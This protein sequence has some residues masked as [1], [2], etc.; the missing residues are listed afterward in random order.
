M[1]GLTSLD[2]ERLKWFTSLTDHQLRRDTEREQGIFIAESEKVVRTALESGIEPLAF[3]L[4]DTRVA[5]LQR[6]LDEAEALWPG[7]P[8][9]VLPR[10][11][12]SQLVGYPHNRGVLCAMARPALKAPGDVLGGAR[13]VAVLEALTD[14]TNVGA[15]FRSAAALGCDGVLLTPTCADPLARRCVRVSMGSVFLVPWARLPEW[16]GAGLEL[17][18]EA[19]FTTC[20]CALREDAL[21]L[22][23]PRLAE[24][25]HLA[26][27]FG[28]EGDG[29][30]REAVDGA[31][32]VARIPMAHGVD[33][34]NVAAAS[35][36]FFWELCARGR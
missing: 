14:T 4:E 17:L 25:E 5:T 18:R 32:L 9:F 13:R 16:P 31:D 33:S 34:L 30:C 11:Q 27:L 36:V 29:L 19:G 6:L 8:V 24:P 12:I 35:A 20:A 2:D 15:V 7:V 10:D 3:L 26:L 21:P 23:D 22:G 1:S 28:T